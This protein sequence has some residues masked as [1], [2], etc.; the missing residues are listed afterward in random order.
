M[1]RQL[2]LLLAA[3]FILL[4]YSQV[5]AEAAGNSNDSGT[6][7]EHFSKGGGHQTGSHQKTGITTKNLAGAT[8]TSTAWMFIKVIFVLAIVIAL[9][10][11][12]LRFI[13][14]R[15]RSFSEGRAI[16]NIGGISVGS[17]RSVQLVKV[18]E[19]IYV[20]GVGENVSLLSEIADDREVQELLSQ[21]QRE[22]TIE[23]SIWKFRD[24]LKQRMAPE[25]KD[26]PGFKN[27]FEE[28]LKQM[29]QQRKQALDELKK[30][31]N[32]K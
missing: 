15:T 8:S 12:L 18:G 9:I 7:A 3:V 25:S 21:D 27:V 19:R 29:A 22:D 20:V 5:N 28:R 1:R 6:V 30:K 4:V 2:I 10:Y 23:N 31:G 26:R 11:I 24:W 13:N 32:P 17:N 16:R 14:A